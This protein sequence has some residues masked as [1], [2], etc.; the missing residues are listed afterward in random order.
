MHSAVTPSAGR[1]GRSGNGGEVKAE[2]RAGQ[3]DAFPA[4]VRGRHAAAKNQ[5]NRP[6]NGAGR[7]REVRGQRSEVRGQRG[8]K[9]RRGGPESQS[10]RRHWGTERR[11]AG[12]ERLAHAMGLNAR[13]PV[14]YSPHRTDRHRGWHEAAK[15]K[16]NRPEKKRAGA[17]PG[18]WAN[19]EPTPWCSSRRR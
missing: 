15:T 6:D 1:D 17:K 12:G 11:D 9:G 5:G 7:G 18:K 19:D 14:A 3:A 16:G 13:P 10:Q 4:G 8:E 2:G